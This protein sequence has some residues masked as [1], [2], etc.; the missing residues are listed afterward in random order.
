MFLSKA[1]VLDRIKMM[2]VV[3]C[4]NVEWRQCVRVSV[5]AGKEYYRR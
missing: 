5:Q 1:K 4:L 2:G 3:V